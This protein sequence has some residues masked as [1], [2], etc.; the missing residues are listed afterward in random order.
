MKKIALNSQFSMI[1]LLFC[2]IFKAICINSL[3]FPESLAFF[4]LILGLGFQKYLIYREKSDISEDYER[5]LKNMES[6]IGVIQVSRGMS[7]R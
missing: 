5:R 6:K 3:N 4:S 1:F 7:N 2:L